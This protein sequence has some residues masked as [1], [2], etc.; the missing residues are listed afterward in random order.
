MKVFQKQGFSILVTER[1]IKFLLQNSA[2]H[3]R[4]HS[5]ALCVRFVNRLRASTADAGRS[6]AAVRNFMGINR[7]SGQLADLYLL[8][9]PH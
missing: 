7:V 6:I 2:I 1:R 3:S 8:F 9:T 5:A 4:L